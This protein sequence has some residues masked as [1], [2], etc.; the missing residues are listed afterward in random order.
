M[1]Y[2]SGVSE[3]LS[4]KIRKLGVK[5]H[6]KPTNTIRSQL[7]HPKD[8]PGKLQA[9]GVIYQIDCKDCEE[10][11]IGET[12]R[13]LHKRVKEHKRESSPMGEHLSHQHQFEE[14]NVQ[15]IDKEE[16]WFQGG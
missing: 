10:N 5:V 7:V 3:A 13:N 14:D 8:K 11:Y 1:P 9:S 16:R 4:R 12:E 6:A 2:V 15:V